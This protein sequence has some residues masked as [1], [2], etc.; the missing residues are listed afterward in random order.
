MR[1]L[2][3]GKPLPHLWAVGDVTGKLMLAHAAAA[4]GTN[5]SF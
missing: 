4:Q 5:L 3:E 2:V 1:V